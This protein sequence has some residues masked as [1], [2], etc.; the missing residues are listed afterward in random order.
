MGSA[1]VRQL[2]GPSR[3]GIGQV[4]GAQHRD[5]DLCLPHFAG[6]RVDDGELLAGVIDKHLVAGDMVLAHGRR[7]PPLELPE[8]I[9]ESRVAITA[10]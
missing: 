9:A 4:R 6:Q 1:P 10:G 2:L 5:E 3:L 7:E 8:E